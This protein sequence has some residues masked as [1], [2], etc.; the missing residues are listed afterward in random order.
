M[1]YVELALEN[2]SQPWGAWT[3][4]PSR[5]LKALGPPG[6]PENGKQELGSCIGEK[7]LA[8]RPRV[9]ACFPVPQVECGFLGLSSSRSTLPKSLL[10]RSFQHTFTKE[11]Q[12]HF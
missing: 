9:S 6:H 4:L 3:G 2:V 12:K 8:E 1:S 10:R 7:G 11:S 5:P